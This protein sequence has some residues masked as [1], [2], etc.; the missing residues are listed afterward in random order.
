[1]NFSYY[2]FTLKAPLEICIARDIERRKTH[3]E[4][5]ARAVYKKSTEFDYG[6]IIDINR[7]L[8]VC[9][10]DILSYIPKN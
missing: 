2:V 4:D 8:E 1:L 6:T 10:K 3:G 9:V 5:A 7:P